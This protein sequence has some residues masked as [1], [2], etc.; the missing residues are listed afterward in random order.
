MKIEQKLDWTLLRKK[1]EINDALGKPIRVSACLLVV[2]DTP[3]QAHFE[4]V[5][6]EHCP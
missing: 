3:G 2:I 1:A 5:C 4:G 6:F